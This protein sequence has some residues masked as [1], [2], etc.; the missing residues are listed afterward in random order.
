M[1]DLV[2]FRVGGSSYALSVDAVHEVSDVGLIS[3][4]LNSG[5]HFVGLVRVRDR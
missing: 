4:R 2:V 1:S 5:R 3:P